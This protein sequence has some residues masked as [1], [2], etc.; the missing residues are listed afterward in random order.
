MRSSVPRCARH[1]KLNTFGFTDQ[2][3]V[4]NKCRGKI[5]YKVYLKR[6]RDSVCHMVKKNRSQNWPAAID[7]IKRCYCPGAPVVNPRTT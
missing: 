7:K 2:L 4:T 3:K 1:G 6:G 5:G